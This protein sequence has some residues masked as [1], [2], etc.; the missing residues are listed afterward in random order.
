MM[1]PYFKADRVCAGY[2]SRKVLNGVDFC[3]EKGTLTGLLGANG[4][5]K[6]TLLKAVCGLLSHEGTCTLEGQVLEQLSGRERAKRISYIPQRSGITI[7]LPLLDVVLMGFEA[8]LGFL[9][10]P[11]KIQKEMAYSAL[12][13]VGLSE[14]AEEDFLTL[15]EG[16]KQ[17]GILARTMVE[18]TGLLL[19]DEPDSALDFYQR[20]RM[21]KLL[22]NM[23]EERG[24]AGLL[25]LHDPGLAL[26]F[27]DQLLL[28]KEGI[29]TA[30]I[31]PGRDSLDTMEN[32]LCEI[33]GPVSLLRCKDRRGTGHL[34]M[35]SELEIS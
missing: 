30:S 15:S 10:R 33:Y 25:C 14:K 8:T 35:V 3:L 27:C 2:G 4:S 16:Q 13:V 20:H 31:H 5:G 28:L 7:S 22:K 1:D 24:K 19:L 23:A 6:T 21:L 11:S 26:E 29:C 9:E 17:L 34:M 32:A 18:N 12:S